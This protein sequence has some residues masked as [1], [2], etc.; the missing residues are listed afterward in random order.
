MAV[1]VV[2]IR[3]VM[4]KTFYMIARSRVQQVTTQRNCMDEIYVRLLDEGT[5]VYRAV[6]ATQL[7]S[8]IYLIDP[9]AS[10]DT[11][12][13]TWEFPPGSRVVVI[14]KVLSGEMRLVAIHLDLPTSL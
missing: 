5:E 4:L 6:P 7:G 12:D 14:R 1:E 11:E 3:T 13:E 10:Y 9:H 8:S 2:T